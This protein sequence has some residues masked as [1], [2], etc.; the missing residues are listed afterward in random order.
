[1]LL[2]ISAPGTK[3]SV[4]HSTAKLQTHITTSSGQIEVGCQST[5]TRCSDPQSGRAREVKSIVVLE[6]AL[7]VIVRISSRE[8]RGDLN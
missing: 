1:M 2:G 6:S 4:L 3:K 7:I 8:K 5:V